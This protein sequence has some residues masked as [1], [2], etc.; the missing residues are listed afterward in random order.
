MLELPLQLPHQPE[1]VAA[2]LLVPLSAGLASGSD[3]AAREAAQALP[4]VG[5]ATIGTPDDGRGFGRICHL[6]L[7]TGMAS[8]SADT[9]ISA[10]AAWVRVA[11]DGRLNPG[12]A[13]AAI[14]DGVATDV[15]KLNRI[16]QSMGHAAL[17]PAAAAG[18]AAAWLSAAAAL[19]P[20]RPPGLHLLLEL[21]ARCVAAVP[22]AALPALPAPVADLARSRGR[23]KLAEAARRLA[24]QASQAAAGPVGAPGTALAAAAAET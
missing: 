23:S 6:A 20:G 8:A 9:R 15:F 12:L 3:P 16:A 21:A 2:N 17:D 1:L 13:A 14:A 24:R 4:A 18:I 22:G 11:L 10:A 7:V 5:A 19:L